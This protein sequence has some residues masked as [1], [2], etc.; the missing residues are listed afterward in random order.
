MW[1]SGSPLRSIINGGNAYF[2][3][4]EHSTEK[5]YGRTHPDC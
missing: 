2:Q 5:V 3:L 1:K 4:S